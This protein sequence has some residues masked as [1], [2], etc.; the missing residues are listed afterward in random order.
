M[1]KKQESK[2][3]TSNYFTRKLKKR[4]NKYSVAFIGHDVKPRESL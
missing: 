2:R 4:K 3:R 1:K